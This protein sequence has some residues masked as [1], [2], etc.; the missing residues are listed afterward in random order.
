MTRAIVTAF[1]L[2]RIREKDRM[3]REEDVAREAGLVTCSSCLSKYL[4][5]HFASCPF[6]AVHP[7]EAA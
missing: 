7:P 3:A 5:R 1:D 2:I 4:P 6:C